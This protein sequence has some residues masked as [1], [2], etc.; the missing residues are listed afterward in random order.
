MKAFE[1]DNYEFYAGRGKE[2][3]FLK[4]IAEMEDNSVWITD[5]DSKRIRVYGIDASPLFTYEPEPNSPVISIS[6]VEDMGHDRELIEDGSE[7]RHHDLVQH[8]LQWPVA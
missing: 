4:E 7:H 6:K 1:K 3:E 2:D 8:L 5:V